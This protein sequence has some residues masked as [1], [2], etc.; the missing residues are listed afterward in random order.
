MTIL[1]DI[2]SAARLGD[3]S[4]G[5]VLLPAVNG[6]TLQV[7]VAIHPSERNDPTN[8]LSGSIL[9]STDG[10]NNNAGSFSF[11]W[12]G[13]SK[14]DHG[15]KPLTGPVLRLPFWPLSGFLRIDINTPQSL[16]Y[17]LTAEILDGVS[18]AQV[19]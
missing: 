4:T 16:R 3:F 12:Q 6:N 9:L 13:N 5:Y 10:V 17:A 1:I 19:K 8:R 11:T 2:A 14:T 15:G 7:T 18:G